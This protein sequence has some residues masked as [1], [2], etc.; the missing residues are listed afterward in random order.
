LGVTV[1]LLRRSILTEKLARRGQHIAREYSVDILE[2][3]RVGDVM[4]K[5]A[6]TVPMNTTVAELSNRIA[7]GDPLIARRQ[8]TLIL[9]AENK[10][11]GIITRGDI[12]RVLRESM[13]STITVMDAGETEL[14]IAHADESLHEAVARMLKHDIG[15]LPVVERAD[16]RKVV[17]YLGR[18]AILAAQ[19]KFYEEEEVR[20]RGP[21]V[22]NA[23]EKAL[24]GLANEKLLKRANRDARSSEGGAG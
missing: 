17:G 5:D 7:Q 4:D 1:L 11:A 10:L 19:A 15:R 24:S 12:L 9:D 22:P 2:L 3:T 8:A 16:Q 14:I 20:A 21:I 23:L 6:P 18:A 13:T